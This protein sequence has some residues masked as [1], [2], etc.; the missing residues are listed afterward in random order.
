MEFLQTNNNKDNKFNKYP[1]K[2]FF[3]AFLKFVSALY[4]E[5]ILCIMITFIEEINDIIKDFVALGF[6]VEIDD[7]FAKTLPGKSHDK[8]L[9]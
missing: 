2:C 9:E 8:L 3:I 4:C 7:Y 6:I 1:N 5:T